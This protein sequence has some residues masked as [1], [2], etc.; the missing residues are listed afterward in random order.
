MAPDASP[1]TGGPRRRH[2]PRPIFLRPSSLSPLIGPFP[3]RPLSLFAPSLFLPPLSFCPLPSCINPLFSLLSGPPPLLYV[4]SHLCDPCSLSL[5][6]SFLFYLDS[7][8]LVRLPFSYCMWPLLSSLF[9]LAHL[10]SPPLFFLS[11]SP[12]PYLSTHS[13]K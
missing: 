1:A 7:F 10:A 4:P 2:P 9:P 8:C 6:L 3:Y 11:D 13:L 5:I 12:T